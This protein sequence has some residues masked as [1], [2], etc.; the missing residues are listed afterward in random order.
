MTEHSLMDPVPAV[1]ENDAEGEIAT[2]FDDIRTSLGTTSVNLIWRHL[3]TFPGALPWCWEA[4]AP[5]LRSGELGELA[6]NLR[7][8]LTGPNLSEMPPEAREALSLSADDFAQIGSTLRGYFRSCTINI[9]SLNAL[10]ICMED[11]HAATAPAAAPFI[12]VADMRQRPPMEKMARL[13]SPSEMPP[14][15]AK[16]A[17]RLNGLGERGDGRIL[18][19]L[20]RYLANWPTFLG[21]T[22]MLIEPLAANGQLGIAID[23]VLVEADA[24]ARQLLPRLNLPVAALDAPT[25]QA[26][27]AALQDFGRNAIAKSIPITRVLLKVLGSSTESTTR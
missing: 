12:P 17:W 16:L 3:A 4:I 6:R 25:H 5:L 26:V 7:E 2:I 20:Y 23:R 9:V 19:S 11:A 18:A 27:T 24:R 8:A 13:L 10:V 15:V 14:H 22:W 1:K 21:A